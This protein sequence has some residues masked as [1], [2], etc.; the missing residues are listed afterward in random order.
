MYNLTT[1]IEGK[2][3]LP[4]SHVQTLIQPTSSSPSSVV[5]DVMESMITPGFNN[6]VV[7]TMNI[8]FWLLFTSLIFLA[9]LSDYNYMVLLNLGISILLYISLC[10]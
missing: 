2:V 9:V 1:L 10:W 7:L 8:C 4:N 6:N 3:S 5:A